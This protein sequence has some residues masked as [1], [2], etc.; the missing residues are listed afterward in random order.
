MIPVWH[1]HNSIGLS[2]FDIASQRL[3]A[4]QR[5]FKTAGLAW[6]L[7]GPHE[8]LL[9]AACSSPLIKSKQKY[10][11]NPLIRRL[12]NLFILYHNL[13]TRNT[14]KSIKGW[15]DLNSSLVST[16]NS[17]KIHL[18]SSWAL[19]QVTWARSFKGAAHTQN[20]WNSAKFNKTPQQ[21]A[22]NQS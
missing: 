3:K 16:E 21:F 10:L 13:C 5:K 14:R 20:F 18:S 8:I 11:I 22:G 7:R 12:I 2:A 19:G 17:S 9:Q 1:A 6:M 15:K 4:G